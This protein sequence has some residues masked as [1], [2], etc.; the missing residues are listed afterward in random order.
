M[1]IRNNSQSGFTAVELLIT[2]IIASMFLFSGYQIYSQVTRDGSEAHKTAVVSNKVNE[3]LRKEV[4]QTSA[5]SS[6]CVL[7]DEQNNVFLQTE[8]VPG[9]GG[10]TYRKT[11]K[12]TNLPTTL[13]L[14]LVKVEGSYNDAGVTKKVEHAVYAN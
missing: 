7:A 10:V 9:I 8:N 11:V 6:G 2:L 1:T 3:R 14:F 13:D 12:C 5:A 4:L